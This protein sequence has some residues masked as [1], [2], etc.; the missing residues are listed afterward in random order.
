MKGLELR[1]IEWLGKTFAE[2]IVMIRQM[3]GDDS[4]DE[5]PCCRNISC[6]GARPSCLVLAVREADEEVFFPPIG[7]D[8]NRPIPS[9]CLACRAVCAEHAEDGD[10]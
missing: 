9:A 10:A 4:S 6:C 2:Q 8:D 1:A 5:A 7:F 3:V